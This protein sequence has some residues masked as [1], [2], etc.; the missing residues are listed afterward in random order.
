[1][2]SP[3]R[4][5]VERRSVAPLTWLATRPRWLPFVLVLVLLLAGLFTPPAVAVVVLV[6]LV[7]LLTWLAYLAWPKLDTGGRFVRVL[8]LALVLGLLVQ[9]ATEL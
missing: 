3:L 2:S 4:R 1:M 8:T 6:V 5:A 9:R 7:G